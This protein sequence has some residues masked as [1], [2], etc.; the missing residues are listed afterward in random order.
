M[1]EAR[2]SVLLPRWMPQRDVFPFS[3]GW[4]TLPPSVLEEGWLRM[5]EPHAACAHQEVY[6]KDVSG[7]HKTTGWTTLQK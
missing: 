2:A 4:L 5:G 1:E 7:I 6:R 3:T